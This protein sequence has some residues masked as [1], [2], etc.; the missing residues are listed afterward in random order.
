MVS[1]P[2][3]FSETFGHI[4]YT[5]TCVWIDPEHRLIYIFLSNRLYPSQTVNK[6]AKLNIRSRIQ[7]VVYEAMGASPATP[8]NPLRFLSSA[9]PE[10]VEKA[11]K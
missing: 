7:D 5:G 4:G 6:L 3:G 9:Q 10:G 11:A 1:S 2:A 8:W